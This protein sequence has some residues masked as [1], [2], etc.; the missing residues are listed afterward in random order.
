MFYVSERLTMFESIRKN[1]KI[2][3]LLL[4]LLIIPSFVLVGI[5]SSYFSGSSPVVA[6][7][8]GQDITQNDWDN[9]HK[10]ESDRQR[11]EQPQM[12]AKLLDTPQARY[13]TLEKLVRDRVL[14]VAAQKMHLVTTDARLARSL[15]E[16]PQIAA[17]RKPDGSLDA[18]GYRAL[19]ATQG[20]TPEGFEASM[21]RN[22]SLNQ[23]L[24]GVVGSSFATSSQGMAA[25]DPLFQRREVQVALFKAADY[26][27]KVR[28]TDEELQAYYQKHSSSFQLPEQVSI[29]YVVFDIDSVRA[30]ITLNEDDLRTYYKENLSRHMGKE[31]RRASHILIAAAKDAPAAEREKAKARAAELLEQLRKSPAEFAALAKRHS[32]DPGSAP[33]GGDLGFFARGAMVKPFEEAAFGLAKGAISDV[34]ETD[35]GYHIIQL[36][37]IKAAREPSFEELRPKLEAELKQQQAQRKYAETAEIFANTVYEQA[38]SLQPVADKLKLKIQTAQGVTRIP[39]PNVVGALANPKLLE[40]LFASDSLQSK[41]NTEAVEL[42]SNQMAAARVIEHQSARVQAFDEVKAQVRQ[43]F[44][45][46]KAAELA[47]QEGQA[48]RDAWAE[49]PAQATGL[50][51]PI[52]LSRD[53][54]QGQS[55]AIV[56]AVLSAKPDALPLWTGVDLGSA[57][58]AVLKV[59]RIMPS[60]GID[61]QLISQMRQQYTQWWSSAEGLAYYE[62]LKSRYQAQIKVPR[63]SSQTSTEN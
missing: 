13:A 28:P 4:L 7:V 14:Q 29:E 49:K 42:G 5:D 31:E 3:M 35:F 56:D 60:D 25:I 21:R 48:K 50:A 58:Y 38:D 61:Q 16:I 23:V 33:Q 24:G 15:Q 19:V 40:A 63:P 36:A 37:D 10:V 41:R 62:T 43:R 20:M 12:D 52:V 45:A 54:A 57:G 44:V 47:R 27:A 1:T 51:A 30:G 2:A 6:R 26:E 8:D 22:L 59:I 18:E 55:R 17:L 39:Q 32:Q 46:D 9:A 53:Q 34:V 11:S